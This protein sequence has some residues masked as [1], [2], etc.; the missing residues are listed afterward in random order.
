V[1]KVRRLAEELLKNFVFQNM[2]TLKE[3]IKNQI[4]G[5]FLFCSK[6]VLIK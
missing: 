3:I 6:I 5:K 4:T 2:R 1:K